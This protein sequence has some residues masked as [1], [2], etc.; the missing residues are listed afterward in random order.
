MSKTKLKPTPSL[1]TDRT[2]WATPQDLFDKLHAQH[3]FTVD[4]CAQPWNA[5]LTRFYTP[6]QNGLLQNY[7]NERVWCNPPYNKGGIEPWV[8]LALAGFAP[9]WVLLL[10]S[11][12]DTVWFQKLLGAMQAGYGPK[13]GL[14]FCKQ[15]ILLVPPP[16]VKA[17]SPTEASIIVE[18]H[19]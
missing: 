15:R 5:K 4:A 7:T 1:T 3:H 6:E 10:P 8:D 17:S 9:L 2:C 19:A 13:V 11:R 12:T 16:G 18:I 14:T